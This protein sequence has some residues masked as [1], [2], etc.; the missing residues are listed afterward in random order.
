MSLDLAV[1]HK[2]AEKIHH[3]I[4]NEISLRSIELNQDL[5]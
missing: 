3:N 1:S 4:G 2:A 5:K